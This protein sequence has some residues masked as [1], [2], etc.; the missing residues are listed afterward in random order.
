[1]S[2]AKNL[3][4]AQVSSTANILCPFKMPYMK[5]ATSKVQHQFNLTTLSPTASSLTQLYNA[6]PKLCTCTF[7]GFVI[8]A[9]KKIMFI[10]NKENKILST[11]HQ[12]ITPQNITLKVRPNYV[13][14]DIQKQTNIL[15]KLP[16][17]L[18]GYVQTYLPPTVMQLSN[19]KS[20]MIPVT[21]A[22]VS[23]QRR[24][25]TRQHSNFQ[26]QTVQG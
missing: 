23:N 25:L 12:N 26:K 13:L 7:I 15:F 9:D 20:P 2:S 16:M 11:T 1:M 24:Q 8:D 4:L 19:Y 21:V 10:G 5:W 3:K 14:N 22:S 6:D 17:T 18:Q